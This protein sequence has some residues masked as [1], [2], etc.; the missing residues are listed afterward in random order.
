MTEPRKEGWPGH[1]ASRTGPPV[2]FAVH[3]QGDRTLVDQFHLHHRSETA[4]GCRDSLTPHRFHK[5]LVERS[6]RLRQ[7]RLDETR[8]AAFATIPIERE[9]TDH[10][11]PAAYVRD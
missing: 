5:G 1:R 7:S 2:L 8:P 3:N 4:R 9:L 11:H 10:Q 6:R